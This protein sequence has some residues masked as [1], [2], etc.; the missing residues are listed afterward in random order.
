MFTRSKKIVYTT[1]FF[2]IAFHSISNFAWHNAN[3]F[4]QGRDTFEHLNKASNTIRLFKGDIKPYFYKSNHSFLYN[5][6]FS[7]YHYPSVYYCIVGLF[8]NIFSSFLGYKAIYLASHLFFILLIISVYKITR[9]RFNEYAGLSAAFLCSFTPIIYSSARQFNLEIAVTATVAAAYYLFLK[10]E[11]CSRRKYTI[12]AGIT[13]GIS[14]L[15]KYTA[16][17][18][19]FAFVLEAIFHISANMKTSEHK[20][21]N[22][23]QIFNLMLFILILSAI[24][25][26]YYAHPSVIKTL[27]WHASYRDY[28]WK[29]P[30]RL[31]QYCAGFF[32]D[33][34]GIIIS[35]LF[36]GLL[37]F[38][39][40]E[41]K[42][43]KTI[44]FLIG[45]PYIIISLIPKRPPITEIEFLMPSLPFA[46]IF[47]G[48]MLSKIKNLF[49][50][51]LI[52][53][54]MIFSLLIQFF[55]A[56]FVSIKPNRFYKHFYIFPL[57]LWG[58]TQTPIKKYACKETLDYIS[59]DTRKKIKI[60]TI[61]H[62]DSMNIF[63]AIFGSYIHLNKK[64]WEI[65]FFS[66]DKQSFY[67]NLQKFDYLIY[68]AGKKDTTLL[69]DERLTLIRDDLRLVKTLKFESSNRGSSFQEYVHLYKKIRQ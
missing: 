60:G 30:Q 35:S 12:L 26:I 63:S 54:A 59:Q 29:I 18:F 13:G 34:Q 38:F 53:I 55:A 17:L 50:K 61:S 52:V 49:R 23:H 3:E 21:K 68:P 58:Y 56:S 28:A 16:L 47:M 36:L 15:L 33:A 69:N 66:V 51:R 19:I 20:A 14:I 9:L 1:I 6:I 27:F 64:P 57:S 10:S 67:N 44:I 62:P 65:V 32:I 7:S 37:I 31:I 11:D 40:K 42:S 22:S 43:R 39:F 4:P 45:I 25:S 2:L 48:G 41:K 8:Y 46:A 5:I 24:T